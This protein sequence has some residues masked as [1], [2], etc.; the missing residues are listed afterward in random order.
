MKKKILILFPYPVTEFIYY[1]FE[2]NQL[3]KKYN[4]KVIF[5]DLSSIVIKKRFSQEWKTKIEKKAIRF[6][7][8]ISWILSFLSIK[9][10]KII[11]LNYVRTIN[12][13][14]FFINLFLNLSKHTIVIPAIADVFSSV[15][16]PKKNVNFFLSRFKQHK[17]NL[18]V[19]F[20]SLELL[21]FKSIFKIINN[22][23]KKKI[24]L[25][26]N[27]N[28]VVFDLMDV[29]KKNKIK[30]IK[31]NFNTYDYSNALRKNKKVNKKKYVIY[32]DNGAPYFSGDAGLKGEKSYEGDIKKHYSELNNFFNKIENIF[33][34]KVIVIPHPKYKSHSPKIKSLNP[35]FNKRK[36]DNSYNALAKLSPNCFFFINKHST[37]ISYP[38][39]FNKP[40]IHIFSSNYNYQREEWQSLLYLAKIIGQKPIDIVNF[41]N[42]EIFKNLKIDKKKYEWF[43][44]NFLTPKD[45]SILKTSNYEIL[46]K[47]T[48]IY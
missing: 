44:Y 14:S 9:N 41:K 37:A 43:K 28:R 16:P 38:I 25:S 23:S 19:Y 40:V 33:K 47:L 17:L 7:F 26:N 48:N 45:K 20:Y 2:I 24:Y 8:L 32:I 34:T 27:F 29:N 10:E 15:K 4:T 36:V 3:K 13:S 30:I 35:Y 1:K 5:H 42:N 39:I 46:N 21:F 6:N 18:K 11:V 22:K 31:E 12:I